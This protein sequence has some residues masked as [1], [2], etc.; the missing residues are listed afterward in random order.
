MKLYLITTIQ[1][2][3]QRITLHGLYASD[4]AAIDAALALYLNP[5]RICAKRIS[6]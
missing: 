1:A 5:R 4:W 3:G 6:K 2:N